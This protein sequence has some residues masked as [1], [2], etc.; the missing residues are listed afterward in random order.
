[1]SVTGS[2][3]SL[4]AL[5][6][7]VVDLRARL[8]PLVLARQERRRAGATAGERLS[9]P[10]HLALLALADGPLTI[11]ALAATTG[12]ALSSATRMV[13][14]LSREGWVERAEDDRTDRR[15]RP[16]RLTAAGRQVSDQASAVLAERVAGLLSLLDEEERA[17]L[18]TAMHGLERALQMDERLRSAS[19]GAAAAG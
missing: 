19:A 13:Q 3:P 2:D 8:A 16:V 6:A 15:R 7:A 5:T 4:D 10:Q 11:S 14:A 18:L 12:V 9:T 1:M 17:A